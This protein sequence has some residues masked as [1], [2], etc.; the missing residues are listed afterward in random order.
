MQKKPLIHKGWEGM[1]LM[2]SL[3][4]GDLP[5]STTLLDLREIGRCWDGY[6]KKVGDCV[7]PASSSGIS[8]V[9]L[10]LGMLFLFPY[11]AEGGV[12]VIK[13]R[14]SRNGS[15]FLLIVM[16][17]ALVLAGCV[18][19][20]E[21]VSKKDEMG[22]VLEK[23][24]T[25]A[26]T[27][28]IGSLDPH[29]HQSWEI[30][31]SGAGETLIHLNDQLEPEA[32]LAKMWKRESDTTWQFTLRDDVRFHNGKI[33]E[34]DDVRK[35][36]LRSIEKSYTAR[37]L[38]QIASI[39]VLSPRELKIVTEKPNQALIA[40]LADPST[41]IVDTE[42][43]EDP[44]S[45]PALTGPFKFSQF[46]KDELL[47]VV[48]FE[49]YWGQKAQLS[50][51]IMKYIADGNSRVMALQSGDV[52]V[53]TDIPIDAIGLLKSNPNIEVLTAPSLRTHMVMFNLDSPLFKERLYREV[54][55]MSIPRE[56]IIDSI[57]GGEGT[58][59]K[60][61]FPEVLP[62]GNVQKGKEKQTV[63]QLMKQ[64][65]WEKQASGI[66]EKNGRPFEVNML[67]F[68]Q[69][70]ELTM[71]AEIIQSELRKEG[72]QITIRQVENIDEALVNDDWDLSMYSMLTA[73]TGDP[74]YFLNL[75]Y[76]SGSHSN[77][78]RYES[79]ALE[80]MIDEL[81]QTG[82]LAKRNELA[83]DIQDMITQDL[84]QAF[85][86]HPHMIFAVRSGV[87]GFVPNPVEFYSN[88]AQVD[89]SW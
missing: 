27:W 1:Q 22:A 74:Q 81:N 64:A 25:V 77:F 28:S 55:D 83:V 3:K 63:E 43:I 41:M 16:L 51:M 57:Y 62:F 7:S 35:S 32:W 38:L 13:N 10:A 84:P 85:I 9:L 21:S 47:E 52:D 12:Y 36:L 70:P 24:L 23:T 4:S 54:V 87:K 5:V 53:A 37:E 82:D 8:N 80:K 88:Y 61:P 20:T 42:T 60:G 26:F 89:V 50:R 72:I 31:S 58:E 14:N 73:H 59:A 76:R 6:P 65:G 56:A 29:G 86:V 19:S 66:W 2:K 69:R 44:D 30:M 75:F 79:P 18:T 40:H 45:Y 39:E 15:A 33:M 17:G 67:T 46:K 68:P 48:R 71:M 34:A 11:M 78:S 49:D